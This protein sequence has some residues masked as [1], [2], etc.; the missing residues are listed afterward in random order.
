MRCSVGD[1][2][3]S[4]GCGGS[5]GDVVALLGMLWLSWECGGSFRDV[6]LCVVPQLAKATVWHPTATQYIF[7]FFS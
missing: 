7:K 1:V 6:V 4:W 3:L 5:V 2:V